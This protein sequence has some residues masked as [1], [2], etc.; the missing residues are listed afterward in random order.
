MC[1]D[2]LDW[3]ESFLFRPLESWRSQ[4]VYF[5]DLENPRCTKPTNFGEVVNNELHHFPDASQIGYG[6]CSSLRPMNA[7][8]KVHSSLVMV[9]SIETCHCA[10]IGID[11]C[12]VSQLLKRELC[13]NQI[14]HYYW[15][16]S[17]VV[18]GY[19]SNHS[20]T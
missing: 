16:D 6:C 17:T 11:C 1:K 4:I 13:N 5:K 12:N 18:L 20:S 19:I 9:K 7:H 3:D 8:G 2:G 15:T 10:K 14:K